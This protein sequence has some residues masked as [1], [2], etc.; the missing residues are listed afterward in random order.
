MNTSPITDEHFIQTS[1]IY[2]GIIFILL[3]RVQGST[4]SKLPSPPVSVPPQVSPNSHVNVQPYTIVS[5]KKA[6]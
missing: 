5:I 2:P 6:L 3:D 4:A 1:F